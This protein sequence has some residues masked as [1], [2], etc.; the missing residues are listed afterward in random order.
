MK[1]L[2]T[3]VSVIVCAACGVAAQ[4]HS[5]PVKQ[6]RAPDRAEESRADEPEQM[7][8]PLVVRLREGGSVF[9][10]ESGTCAAWRVRLREGTDGLPDGEL[11]APV[12]GIE[13]SYLY[14]LSDSGTI[15]LEGPTYLMSDQGHERVG[16]RTCRHQLTLV[17]GAATYERDGRTQLGLF[18]TKRLCDSHLLRSRMLPCR[19]RYHRLTDGLRDVAGGLGALSVERSA[20][21][22]RTRKSTPAW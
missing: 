17:S 5:E 2:A 13:F 16:V 21:C 20:R 14:Q 18:A 11:V 22:P 3:S 10:L 8:N 6:T 19:C 15:S 12:S 4:S 7:Q 1:L 9:V